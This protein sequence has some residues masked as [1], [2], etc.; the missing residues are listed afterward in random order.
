MKFDAY[1]FGLNAKW[2]LIAAAILALCYGGAHLARLHWSLDLLS[3]FQVQYAFFALAFVAIFLVLKMPLPALLML[4]VFAGAFYETRTPL[5]QPRQIFP[6]QRI[7][8]DRSTLRILH[9]NKHYTNKKH[10]QIAQFIKNGGQPFDAVFLMEIEPDDAKALRDLLADT[11]PYSIPAEGLGPDFSLILTRHKPLSTEH[12]QIAPEH[13]RTRGTRFEIQPEGFAQPVILYTLHTRVP[14]TYYGHKKRNAE[15]AGMA[16]WIADDPSPYKILVGDFN[17][18]PYSPYFADFVRDS[19]L[20]YQTYGVFPPG[21]WVSFFT[22][23]FLKIP[24]DHMLAGPGMRLLELAPGP[25]H[26][27]DHH[28][29]TGVFSVT[30]SP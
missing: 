20:R 21:T 19:G 18:T 1:L 27:S 6:P 16:E 12:R 9:Y 13:V 11:Y 29:L 15:L 2:Y 5:S 24:I 23:P 25:S 28:S 26:G 30:S 17:I 7:E 10:D 4:A 14:V 22:L 3:H 8:T